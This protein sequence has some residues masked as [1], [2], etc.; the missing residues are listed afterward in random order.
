[1]RALL[2]LLIA[3]PLVEM[4]VLIRVGAN[5]GAFPTVALVI[6]TAMIGVAL[7]R[8]Q[9]FNTLKRAKW[10]FQHGEVPAQELVDGLC[11]AIAGAFLLTPGFVTDALG[12]A[13]LT[14]PLRIL[15]FRHLVTKM[16]ASAAFGHRNGPQNNASNTLEGEYRREK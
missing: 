10:R 13:L 6:L 15:M 1:M 7:I 11:L 3:V 12:F 14:P 5:I 9:G 8:R 4:M 2:L 16:M